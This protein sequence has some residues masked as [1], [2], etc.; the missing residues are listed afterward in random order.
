MDTIVKTILQIV[1]VYPVLPLYR[2]LCSIKQ[3]HQGKD[4][5]QI[6]SWFKYL[7]NELSNLRIQ[8]TPNGSKAEA[9]VHFDY[10]WVA[11]AA[12][13]SISFSVAA[14]M[15]E[16]ADFGLASRTEGFSNSTT[17]KSN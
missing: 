1:W 8:E 16:K 10:N 15:L 14:I 2:N 4:F 3:S 13:E 9:S 17:Y 12:E 11:T 5:V 6:G 7:K